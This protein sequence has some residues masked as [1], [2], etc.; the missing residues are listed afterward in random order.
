[1][2]RAVSWPTCSPSLLND[3]VVWVC[4]RSL[5]FLHTRVTI[6]V[7]SLA[8]L[9]GNQLMDDTCGVCLSF[10][11]YVLYIL[12]CDVAHV[13]HNLHVRVWHGIAHSVTLS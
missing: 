1:M 7:H 3:A 2:N 9:A 8:L 10:Y 4:F 12:V 6:R 11:F 5:Y 13:A